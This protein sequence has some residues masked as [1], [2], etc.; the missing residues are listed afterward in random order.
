[1]Y[2][3]VTVLRLAYM[4][5][6]MSYNIGLIFVVVT[7]L[8]AGQFVIEYLDAAPSSPPD[9]YQIDEPLLSG[10]DTTEDRPYPA[11]HKRFRP[12]KPEGIFIHPNDSN[13]YRADAVALE[14]GITGG[15]EYVNGSNHPRNEDGREHMEGDK[16]REIPASSSRLKFPA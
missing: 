4:L 7:A 5:V 3:L 8:A 14:M 9:S 15:T 2:W 12:K 10:Q 11:Q 16:T 13:V 1:M 6:A